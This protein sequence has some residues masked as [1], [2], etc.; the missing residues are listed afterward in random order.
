[1]PTCSTNQLT[2]PAGFMFR[3]SLILQVLRP[4]GSRTYTAMVVVNA[5]CVCVFEESRVLD[6][7]SGGAVAIPNPVRTT[8]ILHLVVC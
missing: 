3:S 4:A 7:C 1:M 8:I 6:A 5:F 2:P